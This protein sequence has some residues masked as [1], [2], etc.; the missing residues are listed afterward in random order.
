[1]LLV[2]E[3]AKEA[4][5]QRQHGS[6]QDILKNWPA[7]SVVLNPKTVASFLCTTLTAI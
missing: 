5:R 1:V 3:K 2:P 6:G 7:I 4:N